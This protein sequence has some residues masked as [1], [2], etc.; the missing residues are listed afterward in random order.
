MTTKAVTCACTCI[1]YMYMYSTTCT[2]IALHVHYS[3][4]NSE[5]NNPPH[6]PIQDIY[7]R[8]ILKSRMLMQLW[9]LVKDLLWHS[10]MYIHVHVH[11]QVRLLKYNVSKRASNKDLFP[12]YMLR[13][14]TSI[15]RSSTTRDPAYMYIYMYMYVCT[16]TVELLY[17]GHPE[18][19]TL[20]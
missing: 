8:H 18:M 14:I 10:I 19:R 5:R 6:Q 13:D 2:C 11:I 3:W 20:W 16:C 7:T 15:L 9:E 1:V 17:S 4:K 12:Y